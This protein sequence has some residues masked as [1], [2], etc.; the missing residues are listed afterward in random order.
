[1]YSFQWMSL[2]LVQLMACYIFWLQDITYTHNIFIEFYAFSY[3]EMHVI[4]SSAKC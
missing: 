3:E 2:K 1:M 4:M